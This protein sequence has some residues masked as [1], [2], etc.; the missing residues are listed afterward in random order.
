MKKKWM[1]Q[2]TRKCH[3]SVKKFS[4]VLLNTTENEVVSLKPCFPLSKHKIHRGKTIVCK[5][6][7]LC[8]DAGPPNKQLAHV[9]LLGTEP[10]ITSHMD[11][12]PVPTRFV[13][14]TQGNHAAV[15]RQGLVVSPRLKLPR[16]RFGD[17]GPPELIRPAAFW[18]N[19]MSGVLI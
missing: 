7:F 13:K 2:I 9:S 15:Q 1:A 6:R 4:G 5:S 16:W 14:H 19:G 10:G 3:G 11:T 8:L 12:M 18:Q 17:M